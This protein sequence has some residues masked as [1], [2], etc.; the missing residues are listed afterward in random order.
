MKALILGSNGYI[1][2]HLAFYL[3]NYG[4]DISGIDI[5]D[6]SALRGLQYTA[7][8]VCNKY[9]FENIDTCVDFIFYFSGIT[10][11]SKAYDNYE[12]YLDVNEKG[13]LN[14]LNRMRSQ[15]S[16][17]RIIF[18]STRLIYKGE[19]GKSLSEE[20]EKEFKS[21]YALNKW[22]GE[23]ILI[24]FSRYFDISFSIFRICV[25][26]G[27]FVGNEYSYGTIGFFLNNALAG[28]PI[29]L[30]GTGEQKRTFSHIEDICNQIYITI[31]NEASK[32]QI[33]NLGGEPFSLKEVAIAIA[34]KYAT[35]VE[36]VEWPLLEEKME[37]GD[38]IFNS[39][40]IEQLVR[41]PYK[42]SFYKWLQTIK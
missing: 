18:P 23:N 40:K 24:Q 2:K 12:T 25:P 42:N 1:G 30:Y 36:Y 5:A 29:T 3:I 4:W 41:M 16:T 37:S 34:Q 10:G 8:N 14:L 28:K 15:K 35:Q 7:L 19:K 32:N 17:A 9:E 11:T 38:T 39:D 22:F 26:Y 13:L 20:A 33:Y 6:K 27:S 31:L 21:I